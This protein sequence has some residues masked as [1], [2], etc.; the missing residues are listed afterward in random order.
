MMKKRLFAF[1]TALCC[2]ASVMAMPVTAEES[3]TSEAPKMDAWGK[4]IYLVC[5]VPS[6]NADGQASWLLVKQV[7]GES[8]VEECMAYWDLTKSDV[9]WRSTE[10][11][12]IGCNAKLPEKLAGQ[13]IVEEGDLLCIDFSG[14]IAEVYPG[15]MHLE[16]TDTVTNLGAAVEIG[17]RKT[18]TITEENGFCY[19]MVDA[20]GATH[21]YYDNISNV[22]KDE[23]TLLSTA[24][25]GDQVEWI[26]YEDAPV[27]PL[28]VSACDD[29]TQDETLP[30]RD[31]IVI[32]V[33]NEENPQNYIVYHPA[34]VN[35]T[36][37]YLTAA[38][39]ETFLNE[40]EPQPA[41]GDILEISGDLLYTAL[42]GT[43]MMTFIDEMAEPVTEN[44]GKHGIDVTGNVLANEERETYCIQVS[45]TMKNGFSLP[46]ETDPETGAI[47]GYH[48]YRDAFI[49]HGYVQPDGIDLENIGTGDEMT[50]LM[51]NGFPVIPTAISRLGD[52]NGD[53]DVSIVDVV[54]VNRHVMGADMART[55]MNTD[56]ADFDKNGEVT[57]EDSLSILKRLVGLV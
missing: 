38:Q 44:D 26:F 21:Y 15:C 56:A 51:Y 45:E 22:L 37:C 49:D 46:Y 43:N 13:E 53:G 18:L 8:S 32:G 48:Y 7:K 55:T 4:G 42:A 52:A 6:R 19:T 31:F 41:Y 24:K 2:G 9:V 29:D 3:A 36:I 40:G 11:Y 1:L 47:K 34:T 28:S 35:W 12:D 17:E 39:V 20:E 10:V 54:M 50:F 16:E 57:H 14:M 25:A 23:E 5:N 30:V 27:M 33:D